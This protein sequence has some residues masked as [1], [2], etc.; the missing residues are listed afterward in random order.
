MPLRHDNAEKLWLLLIGVSEYQDEK[1]SALPYSLADCQ[2]LANTLENTTQGFPRKSVIVHCSQTSQKPL[3]S[4]VRESLRQVIESANEQD[5]VFFYFSGHGELPKPDPILE[6]DNQQVILCLSDTQTDKLIDTG[7]SVRKLLEELNN[8]A[9]RQKLIILDACHSGGFKDYSKLPSSL[10]KDLQQAAHTQKHEKGFYALLS[11]DQNQK[12]WEFEDL[13]HGVFTYYLIQGLQGKAANNKG[14]VDVYGLYKFVYHSTLQHIDKLNQ[15]RNLINQQKKSRNPTCVLDDGYSLQTPKLITEAIGE[16]TFIVGE[17][18]TKVDSQPLRQALVVEGFSEGEITNDLVKLLG[19]KGNYKLDYWHPDRRD[20]ADVKNAIQACLRSHKEPTSILEK[21]GWITSHQ[22]SIA[23]L[24]LRG[25]LAETEAGESVLL[26]DNGV[27]ISCSWLRQQLRQSQIA[28]Q[29]VILDFPGAETLE[30]WLEDLQVES[31]SN[32]CL[33]AGAATAENPE[34]FAQALLTS[35]KAADSQEGLPVAGWIT[36]IQRELIE[37]KFWRDFWLGS[38]KGVI[39]VL[40]PG[41]RSSQPIDTGICPYKGLRAFGVKDA[42]YFYGREELIQILI[43]KLSQQS[44][45]PVVGASGSGKSSVVQAGLMAQLRQGKQIPGSEQWWNKIFRPGK[46][47]LQAL[48]STLAEGE[49]KEERTRQRQEVEG[50]LRLGDEGF[51]RW[52]RQRPEPMVVLVVDQFEEIFTLA[53]RDERQNFLNILLEALEYAADKFKLVITLRADFIASCLEVPKF[54]SLLQKFNVLVSPLLKEEDYRQVIEKPAEKVGLAVDPELVQKLL[55]DLLQEKENQATGSLP[56][57][58]F[59][60]EQLWEERQASQLTLEAYQRKIGGLQGALNR[61][62]EAVYKSLDKLDENAR[63]CAQ[64]I[65]LK[66][67][68]LGEGTEDTRRRVNKS[69]LLEGKYSPNLVEQTLQTLAAGRLIVLNQEEDE[70]EKEDVIGQNRGSTASLPES[71]KL[72]QE[73]EEI[74]KEVTVEVAHEILIRHWSSLRWWLD[75]NRSRER[76]QREIEEKA[77]EWEQK[78]K[79]AASLLRGALLKR[80]EELYK[81]YKE[82]FSKSEREFIQASIRA[83]RLTNGGRFSI[84]LVIASIGVFAWV[85]QQQR[86]SDLKL[87]DAFSNT[88]T[89]EV[90]KSVKKSLPRTL[91]EA[92]ELVKERKFQL[93]LNNY[94]KIQ[95][96][97]KNLRDK[98][99]ENSG[100]FQEFVIEEKVFKQIYDNS[101]K[102]I[103]HAIR[104]RPE[105]LPKLRKELEKRDWGGVD[106]EEGYA[107]FQ[108]NSTGAIKI[109]HAILMTELGANADINN[110]GIL[111]KDEVVFIPCQTLKDIEELWR[112]FTDNRCGWDFLKE[113]DDDCRELESKTLA[114][115]VIYPS[116]ITYVEDYMRQCPSNLVSKR[117]GKDS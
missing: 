97:A 2:G 59:V 69:R 58:Q 3:L 72:S 11:C 54:A 98:I 65:F 67:T 114:R 23:L 45:L 31:Q 80:A 85:Q 82:E 9:A 36:Q 8:C 14:E 75:E 81:H 29:I 21:S 84:L 49:T 16:L 109:T 26:L 51:V 70:E 89:P 15:Q 25:R 46:Y 44:F 112:S 39:E 116:S 12:S 103:V 7:L 102:G 117:T 88:I 113:K 57:L 34:Q 79:L 90:V 63:A 115:K 86:Q 78:G 47:P 62:A 60:L 20:L 74:K 66:L 40:P 53:S 105:A 13:G 48:S 93:A 32:Q 6:P 83:R 110:D 50:L 35:L 99:K 77:K 106:L 61:K 87:Q 91:E 18:T 42:R 37:T 107:K 64:W 24:Y 92:D 111:W 55:E 71:E 56:L 28:Q 95:I 22:K 33:V 19:S 43:N 5:T 4:A 17:T 73:L 10:V 30:D 38:L 100:Y 41:G 94:R 27:K 108:E 1:L 68:Q 96:V 76:H 101:E 104:Q 52:L